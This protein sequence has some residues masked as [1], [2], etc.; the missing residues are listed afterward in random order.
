MIEFLETLNL[1]FR[2]VF[3][4]SYLDTNDS[5]EI[6]YP[7]LTYSLNLE[8][9]NRNTDG[10][11]LDIDIFDN[12]SSTKNIYNIESLIRHHFD[13]E[14]KFTDDIF[15]RYYFQ[16]SI[17]IPTLSDTLKRRNMQLYCKI[18]WRNK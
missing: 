4:E 16:R 15:L 5:E 8:N 3:P 14:L 13:Y 18:D 6:I 11:Y 2:E 7:Y 1:M 9:I 10:F 12:G 17:P